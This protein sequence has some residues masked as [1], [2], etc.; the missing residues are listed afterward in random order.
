V[1]AIQVTRALEIRHLWID[2]LCIIQ[3][4]EEDWRRQASLMGQV[5]EHTSCNI[6][7]TK[8]LNSREG[9]FF[10]RDPTTL[11]RVQVDIQWKSIPS[12]MYICSDGEL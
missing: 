4:S 10:E 7:A 3:D 2:S 6:A 9:L 11:Q 8:A 1:E 5:Y 12:A